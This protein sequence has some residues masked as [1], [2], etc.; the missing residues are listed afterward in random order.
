MKKRRMAFLV[1]AVTAIMVLTAC[2]SAQDKSWDKVKEKGEFVLGLDDS[3]P[4]MGFRDENH[5]IVGFDVDAAQEI[6]DRLKITLKLQPVDWVAKETELNT[7]NIDCIWNGFTITEERKK[8]VLFSKPYMNNRQV[9]VVMA[10]SSFQKLGDFEGKTLAL[11]GGSSASDALDNSKD[12]K[13]KL[14]KVI[15]LDDNM[16][17]LMDLK[18]GGVDV[19]LMDEVVAGYNIEMQGESFR[20]IEESLGNE[21]F[22]I[23][24]RKA[25]IQL[26]EKFQETLEAMAKDG[27]LAKISEKWMGKDT[28]VVGK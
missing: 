15:E 10:D 25:D 24:F 4:P 28:T 17:A 26:M 12:F 11:Q 27:T 14:N 21:Q 23:G 20:I 9:L 18:N 16:L 7:G 3:F 5:K 2:G 1:L 8:E 13:E 19:V 6:C 22:G